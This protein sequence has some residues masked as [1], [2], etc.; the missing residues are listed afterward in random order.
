[1]GRSGKESSTSVVKSE[2][3]ERERERERATL[4]AVTKE[5]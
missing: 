5:H 3:R 4:L 2:A 1:M